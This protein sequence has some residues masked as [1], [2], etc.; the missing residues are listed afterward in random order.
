MV[1]RRRAPTTITAL[2]YVRF[3]TEHQGGASP[4]RQTTASCEKHHIN[5]IDYLADVLLRV[6]THPATR[7]VDLLPHR[8][9]RAP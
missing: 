1:R 6:H 3:S 2:A 9:T 8:W 7:V 5:P 4:G